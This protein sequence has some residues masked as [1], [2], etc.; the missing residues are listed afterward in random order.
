MYQI[1]LLYTY[2]V[3]SN[4]YLYADDSCLLFQHKEVTKIKKKKLTKDLSNVCDWFMDNK[5]SMY[6]GEGKKKSVLFSSRH[7]LKLVKEIDI[8][9]KKSSNISK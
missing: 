7:N 9:S 1:F 4:F 3:D 6:T 5:L 2:T 8:K